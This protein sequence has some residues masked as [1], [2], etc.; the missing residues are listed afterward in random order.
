MRL[1]GRFRYQGETYELY[2][3]KDYNPKKLK[4][5]L[6]AL[7][8]EIEH[9]LKGKQTTL[10]LNDLFE[11]WI[12]DYKVNN[13]QGCLQTYVHVYN[14]MIKSQMGNKKVNDIN[15][16]HIQSFI[17]GLKEN[18][19]LSRIKLAHVVLSSMFEVAIINNWIVRNPTKKIQFPK[20]IK[21]NVE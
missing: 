20:E 3:D 5:E 13:K 17:N 8:Y 6:D 7:R 18:Y 19:S 14:T 11:I 12:K 21:K 1:Y 15:H 9:G 2:R 10:K 4:K 16:N